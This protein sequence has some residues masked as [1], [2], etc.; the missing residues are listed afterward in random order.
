MEGA[1][2]YSYQS[3]YVHA[4]RMNLGEEMDLGE[5]EAPQPYGLSGRASFERRRNAGILHSGTENEGPQSRPGQD[6][7]SQKYGHVPRDCHARDDVH[8]RRREWLYICQAVMALFASVGSAAALC[9]AIK[10][11][12]WGPEMP[13]Y[14]LSYWNYGYKFIEILFAAIYVTFLGQVLT[15][16]AFSKT[17]KAFNIAEVT[18]RNWVIQPG[19][20]VTHYE[21]FPHAGVSA[22]G[23]LTTFATISTL[24]YISACNTLVT[25]KVMWSDWKSRG[26]FYGQVRTSYANISHIIGACPTMNNASPDTSCVVMKAN[27]DSYRTFFTFLSD[28]QDVTRHSESQASR[29]V[30]RTI[31]MENTTLSSAWMEGYPIVAEVGGRLVNNV[32]LA[33]PHAGLSTL[34]SNPYNASVD[35]RQPGSTEDTD[36]YDMAASV[37]SPAINVMCT[38]DTTVLDDVFHWGGKYNG[39]YGAK[40]DGRYRP[41]FDALAPPLQWVTDTREYMPDAD[42]IYIMARSNDTNATEYTL[43]QLRSILTSACATRFQVSSL[44]GNMTAICG[45]DLGNISFESYNQVKNNVRSSDAYTL[46]PSWRDLAVQWNMALTPVE[47]D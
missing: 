39:T 14:V 5:V 22:L 34:Y 28:W 43:C 7:L 35:I 18:M 15:R 45:N 10:G 27:G 47:A 13:K 38:N 30:A 37:V 1:S 2:A 25:P 29:P 40:S 8:I 16:R 11:Q 36:G 26:T 17:S 12:E 9:I 19:S 33:I 32:T 20:L 46:A 44:S 6:E 21:G 24:F 23:V 3:P 31:I 42:S 4:S 41:V